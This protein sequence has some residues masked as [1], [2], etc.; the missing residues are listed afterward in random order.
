MST[1]TS[2]IL[3]QVINLNETPNFTSIHLFQIENNTNVHIMHT[4]IFV[5]HKLLRKSLCPMNKYHLQLKNTNNVHNLYLKSTRLFTIEQWFPKGHVQIK[6][7]LSI[8][9]TLN[10][11]YKLNIIMV[12][13]QRLEGKP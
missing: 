11:H 10:P 2:N 12:Y 7:P 6:W 4:I 13:I 5:V 3:L 1:K 9:K 8:C